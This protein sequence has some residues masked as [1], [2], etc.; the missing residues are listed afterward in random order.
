M[1][2]PT[3]PLAID[4]A[5]ARPDPAAIRAAGYTAVL[6]YLSAD[7]TK[8]LSAAEAAALLEAGLGIGLIWETTA[9]R[10]QSGAEAGAADGEAAVAQ[11]RALGFP[12]GGL[13]LANL[14]DFAAAAADL[15]E[16]HDYYYAFR[17]VPRFVYQ[18]GGYGTGWLIDQLVAAG[19]IGVWWQNAMDDQGVSGSVVSQHASIYQRV[20][21]SRAIAGSQA[22]D[23][24]EDV[25]GFGPAE[26]AWWLPAPVAPPPPP[27]P[28]APAPVLVSAELVGTY[29]DGSTRTLSL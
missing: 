3:P 16:I 20:T 14:G 17:R 4:Y 6:R 11:A 29:S 13:L 9:Q 7:P 22:A 19:A 27:P 28:P 18:P 2:D 1:S 25:Y 26:P 5:W 10:S 23:F 24:D 8:N 15:A 21:P 12:A